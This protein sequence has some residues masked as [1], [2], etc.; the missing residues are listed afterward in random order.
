MSQPPE[1]AEPQVLS[2]S[3]LT[4][5]LQDCVQ[6]NFSSVWVAGEVSD[7]SRPQSGHIYMTLKDA[8]AQIRAV[9][10]RSAAQWLKFEIKDGMQLLCQG[11]LDIYPPRGSYQLI[12]RG[13]EMRGEGAAQR[14]LR[15]LQAK[16]AA[17]GLFDPSLKRPLPKFPNSIAIVTSP[18]GAAIR[19]FLEVAKRRWQ[20]TEILILPSRVQGDG[21]AAEIVRGI[22]AANRMSKE[23]DVLVVTR[24][25]GSM[26][27][28]WG[29]N[30][31]A[32][33]RAIRESRIPVVSAVGHEID[34]TL[35]DLAAD[36]RAATPTEAAELILPSAAEVADILGHFQNR[37]VHGLQSKFDHARLQLESLANARVL[38]RPEEQIQLLSRRLDEF[39][40]R[41]R[42]AVATRLG[43]SRQS[44]AQSARQLDTLSP[45]GVLGRGYSITQRADNDQ[46]VRSTGDVQAGDSMVTRLAQGKIISKVEEVT[47]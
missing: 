5:A 37:M 34:V 29:F 15:L 2:V 18:T 14:S 1:P 36:A 41:A 9:I 44:L 33:V 22:Q 16:L 31:E 13:V 26:E 17:E 46:V 10:W 24:G 43:T 30:D 35:S 27:D 38:R 4:W 39:D 47:E 45:L 28:L 42:R 8:D 20:G 19:D 32:V 23:L 7:L 40:D 12:V 3:Q 21:S 11:E 6:A 25:G